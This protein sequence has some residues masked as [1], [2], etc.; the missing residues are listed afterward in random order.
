MAGKEHIVVVTGA[1]QGLGRGI[2]RAFGSLGATVYLTGRSTGALGVTAAEVRANGGTGIAI[3]C[4]HG[5]DAQTKAVFDQVARE[6]G[7]LDI[8]V[9]N[10]A[11]VYP[12]ALRAEGG[13]WEKPLK[14][15]DMLDIGLRSNY[16]AAYYAAPLMVQAR[17]GLI[18]SI[19]F[20]GAVSYFHGAAYGSAKAG[21]DKM[22]FDMAHDLRPYGVSAVSIWP[23]FVRTEAIAAIPPEHVPPDL[24]GLWPLFERP[25]FT[26]LVIGALANDPELASLS[27]Q[28]LI[29]AELGLRY[30][31]ADLDGKQPVSFRATMGKP[32]DYAGLALPHG[33]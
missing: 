27:G 32:I 29:G 30:G 18:A 22:M 20:Y 1:S 14:L 19:S 3:T 26:G 11:A 6:Q 13:F 2:A 4:D 25:E 28:T 9:N 12:D 23:G 21:T 33:R 8:L 10:A 7:R 15:V 17:R 24:A 5:D 16:V 31:I